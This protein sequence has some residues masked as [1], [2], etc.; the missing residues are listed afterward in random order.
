MQCVMIPDPEMWNTPE[1]MKEAQIVLRS[2]EDF[3]PELFGLPQMNRPLDANEFSYSNNA[4]ITSSKSYSN[5]DKITFP[6]SY[7]INFR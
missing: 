3:Q 2:M 4:K 1:H 6:K 7:S 5:N